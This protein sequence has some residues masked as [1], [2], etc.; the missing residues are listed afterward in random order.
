MLLLFKVGGMRENLINLLFCGL[1]VQK[2]QRLSFNPVINEYPRGI[3]LWREGAFPKG[4]NS[5]IIEHFEIKGI[6][7]ALC[8][9]DPWGASLGRDVYFQPVS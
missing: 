4:N 2:A 9:G 5:Q 1:L 7:P 8:M 3:S 6:L